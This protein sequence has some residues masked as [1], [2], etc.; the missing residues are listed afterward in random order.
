MYSLNKELIHRALT[1]L[2]AILYQYIQFT[3]N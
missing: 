3:L 1:Y 2:L